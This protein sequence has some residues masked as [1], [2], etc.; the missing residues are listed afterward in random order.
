MVRLFAA[1]A[2]A[3]IFATA[4][5][6]AEEMDLATVTCGELMQADRQTIG[7]FLIWIDGYL[8]ARSGNTRL[9]EAWLAATGERVAA[10]CKDRPEKLLLPALTEPR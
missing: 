1:M 2:C 9:A 10:L 6:A 8:S 3:A 5:S 4:A 7:V